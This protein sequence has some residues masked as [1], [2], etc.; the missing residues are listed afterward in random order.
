MSVCLYL[1]GKQNTTSNVDKILLH[2]RITSLQNPIDNFEWDY[3]RISSYHGDGS[4]FLDDIDISEMKELE[5]EIIYKKLFAKFGLGV[6]KK[7]TGKVAGLPA[8]HCYSI[9]EEVYSKLNVQKNK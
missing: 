7:E 6:S 4:C 5:K 2:H 8:Y 9:D 1:W 3:G